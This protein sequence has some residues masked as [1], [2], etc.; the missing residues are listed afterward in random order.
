MFKKV[1]VKLYL[2]KYEDLSNILFLREN[3]GGK[4]RLFCDFYGIML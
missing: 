4:D 3:K 1:F 2:I